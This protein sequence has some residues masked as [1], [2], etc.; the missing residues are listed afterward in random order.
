MRN[1]SVC[2]LYEK[3]VCMLTVCMLSVWEV[4]LYVRSVSVWEVWAGVNCIFVLATYLP[5]FLNNIL[6]F[7]CVRLIRLGEGVGEWS[8]GVKLKGGG[9]EFRRL[10]APFPVGIRCQSLGSI[11]CYN[12]F[13][14]LAS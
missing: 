4:C 9:R 11:I 13:T 2:Y 3:C 10:W 7:I 12:I 8:E 14:W 6:G 5:P 1:V